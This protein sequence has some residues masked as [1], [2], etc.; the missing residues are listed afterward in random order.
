MLFTIVSIDGIFALLLVLTVLLLWGRERLLRALN[1]WLHCGAEMS[2]Q[3]EY[4][5]VDVPTTMQ[6]WE[7]E[8]D[9]DDDERRRECSLPVA[10]PAVDGLFEDVMQHKRLSPKA[11]GVIFAAYVVLGSMAKTTHHRVEIMMPNAS[12][13]LTAARFGTCGI[14][15]LA[16]DVVTDQLS[17]P[18]V[19]WW[20]SHVLPMT[21]TL[22]IAL[23]SLYGAPTK[24]VRDA[25]TQGLF[26]VE[27]PLVAPAVYAIG[28]SLHNLLS[29]GLLEICCVVVLGVVD[30][31]LTFFQSAYSIRV[32]VSSLLVAFF[33]CQAQDLLRT[34][35]DLRPATLAWLVTLPLA[36]L[37]TAYAAVYAPPQRFGIPSVELLVLDILLAACVDL[38]LIAILAATSARAS[39]M[40]NASKD[41]ITALI[42]Y[43]FFAREA[44]DS[45]SLDSD[46]AVRCLTV[47]LV[48]QLAWV[49]N[50]LL[51]KP[52][53]TQVPK[54]H[55]VV[56]FGQDHLGYDGQPSHAAEALVTI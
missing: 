20:V 34:H 14:L 30:V 15:G 24:A 56:H 3:S 37:I 17:A 52:M 29:G 16:I 11:L 4:G 45:P 31:A 42:A 49:L 39:S 35:T 41:A 48:A 50:Q 51:L 22:L 12:C 46:T 27:L 54:D 19:R 44:R 13:A 9:D 23:Y 43:A 8:P 6:A 40:L 10:R 33:L 1:R 28:A 47:L 55:A 2:P 32:L 5:S 38:G 18:D 53:P 7:V 21:A 26:T 25:Q 36:G